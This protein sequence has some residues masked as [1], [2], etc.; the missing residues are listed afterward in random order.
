MT[1]R[2]SK[3]SFAK[4]DLN[5]QFEVE[6]TGVGIPKDR[7]GKLFTPFSQA[8]AS[9]ARTYGGTGLGLAI[10]RNLVELMGGTIKVESIEGV[11][12]NFIFNIHAEEVKRSDIP[13]YQK[14]GSSK[15]SNSMVLLVW[16]AAA[17][18]LLL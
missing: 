13:K 6:D 4:N 15:F 16:L 14:T 8:D 10:S 18:V 9:T 11:G 3:F 12:S 7:I 1:V 2:V 5:I 17:I